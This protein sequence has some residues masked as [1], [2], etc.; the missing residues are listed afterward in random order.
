MILS[1]PSVLCTGNV[2]YKGRWEMDNNDFC[3]TAY[4]L[5]I[6]KTNHHRVKQTPRIDSAGQK[7][8]R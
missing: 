4:G 8:P 3:L 2:L 6:S 5:T 7:T 1:S